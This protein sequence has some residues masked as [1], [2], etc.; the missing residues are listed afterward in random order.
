[1][2]WA[3]T[4]LV[5]GI[6]SSVGNGQVTLPYAPAPVDNPLRGLVPYAGEK[7]ALFPHSME[8]QYLPL[9]DVMTGPN[10]FNWQPLERLLN[11]VASRGHQTVFRV[12]M[13]YPGRDGIPPFLEEQGV[14]VTEWLNTNTAPFPPKN[15]R[16][17]DYSDPRLRLA[18]QNFIAALGKRYDGDPRVGYITAGLL[19]TW[20]E[21]HTYPRGELMADKAVQTE[22]MDAY[23]RHFR[24]TP[25]L[26]RYPAGPSSWAYAANHERRFGYHDDSFAWATLETGRD[27]DDWFFVPAMK[28]GG[29]GCVDRWKT[30]PIGGEIRPELWGRIF[31]E[32]FQPRQQQSFER[33]VQQTH[34][35]WLMD[36]GLFSG[37]QPA[38]R[39][40]NA[41]RQVQKMGYEFHVVAASVDDD[42]DG[43]TLR[44]SVRNTGVAPFYHDWT[45]QVGTLRGQQADRVADTDMDVQ[46]L[47]P[48]EIR[49]YTWRLPASW[50][51]APGQPLAVR[52]PNPLQNG[53]P[54]RF[55]NAPKLQWPNGWLNLQVRTLP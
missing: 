53:K 14:S 33:C 16:T 5:C 4:I 29:P 31:D 55:A 48:G 21:W 50:Q 46:K 11:D 34:V 25:V 3:L 12:W 26:L 9:S 39:I 40:R 8:F 30:Q 44:F 43:A 38:D 17:P 32:D 52:I 45:W 28:A 47:L 19:G 13:E 49:E 18:L 42:A 35:T 41:Q 10:A 22:I 2:R 37:P 15:V 7:R 24:R 1:M 6:L 36:T 51:Q 27:E 20:G 23:E 54:L